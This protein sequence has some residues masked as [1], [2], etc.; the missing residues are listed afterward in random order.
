MGVYLRI[1]VQCTY[2]HTYIHTNNRIMNIYTYIYTCIHTYN[3]HTYNRIIQ[4][5]TCWMGVYRMGHDGS[6][7]F[8]DTLAWTPRPS[9]AF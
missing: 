4:D 2:I 1:G 3:I 8:G 7:I 9:R 5:R 6:E